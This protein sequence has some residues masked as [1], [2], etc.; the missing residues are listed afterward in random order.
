MRRVF[1]LRSVNRKEEMLMPTFTNQAFLSYNGRQTQ[2]NIV[3]GQLTE[4]LT[5]AKTAIN[6]TY[7]PGDVITYAVS[8][9]NSSASALTGLT[10][11]DD[12][13]GY[14]AGAAGT[15]Y[16]LTYVADS[17]RY[18]QNGVLQA[19]PTVTAGPPMS[20][21]N[22]TV[23][24]NGNALLIYDAQVNEFAPAGTTASITNI[25]T[26][27]GQGLTEPVTASVNVAAASEAALSIVKSLC[28]ATVAENGQITYTFLIQN[29]GSLAA[30]AAAGVV[31]SDRFTP[32][33]RDLAVTLNGTAL[34]EG[35]GYTYDA[36]T[37]QFDTVAGA[38]TVPAA[39]YAQDVATGAWTTTPGLATLVVTGTL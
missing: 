18:Y 22:L 15:V 26:L 36:A 4:V 31:V 34:A 3:T 29:S 28:P 20:I 19:A 9:V 6:G 33:L 11:S 38:V 30:D 16:P 27:T 25:A 17:A 39:T 14:V 7:R 32:I 1:G 5:A 37:G 8:L 35:T 13:G 10:L 21:A 23:P 2:S 24:A 12:L